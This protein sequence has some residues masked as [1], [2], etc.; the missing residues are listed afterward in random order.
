MFKEKIKIYIKITKPGIVLGNLVSVV[1]GFL[2]ASK[3]KVDFIFLLNILI[4]VTTIIASSCVFNNIIDRNIDKKMSRTKNRVLVQ[5]LVSLKNSVIYGIVLGVIGFFNLYY[6]SNVLSVSLAML[7]FLIYVLIYSFYMKLY[8]KYSMLVGSIAGSMPP[9]IGYCAVTNKFDLCA[10]IL[11]IIFSLWQIPH[12][13]AI[14]ILHEKDYKTANIPIFKHN[15]SNIKIFI[16]FCIF[17]FCI[18]TVMLNIYKYTDYKYL[19]VCT[20]M[21]ILWLWSAFKKNKNNNWARSIFIF[22]ILNIIIF[23][24]MISINNIII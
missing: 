21:N 5:N 20:I 18:A 17:L 16:I 9:L 19:I 14:T 10:S 23:N 4:S 22:S 7:G 12:F 8:S 13:Y 3:E 2:L 15:K 6:R 1:G 24:F 11:L